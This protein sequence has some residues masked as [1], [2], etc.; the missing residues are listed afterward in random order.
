MEL[1]PAH[2]VSHL[3]VATPRDGFL[4]CAGFAETRNKVRHC[5]AS[6]ISSST[7]VLQTPFPSPHRPHKELHRCTMLHTPFPSPDKSE[8]LRNCHRHCFQSQFLSIPKETSPLV[9]ISLIS[10]P[11]LFCST[12]R[13]TQ[14]YSFSLNK[15][16]LVYLNSI[17]H[18][19]LP[20]MRAHTPPDNPLCR[21]SAN[22]S[23]PWNHFQHHCQPLVKI[24]HL[25]ISRT[26]RALTSGI[27]QIWYK[28]VVINPRQNCGMCNSLKMLVTG[29]GCIFI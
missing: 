25:E 24:L 15:F 10:P 29:L 28:F 1:H 16:S 2:E 27:L 6:C 8:E 9:R 21:H 12:L 7:S 3:R 14:I 23:E 11:F 18:D 26:S 13:F 20:F 22:C 19:S 4:Q 5:H 17:S